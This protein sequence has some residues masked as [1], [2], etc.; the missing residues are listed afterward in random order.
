MESEYAIK[1]DKEMKQNIKEVVTIITP[2]INIVKTGRI[3][4]LLENFESVNRQSYPYIEHLVIDGASEDGT[5]EILEEY[6]KKGWIKYVSE[7]DQGS[8]DAMNK[9]VRIS[10][11]D[12][13]LILN[14]DDKFISDDAIKN[15]LKQ[16]I[17]NNADFC[18]SKARCVDFYGNETPLPNCYA[19]DIKKIFLEMTISH[20]TMLCKKSMFDYAL[21]SLDLEIGSDFDWTVRQCLHGAK[22][23]FLN[24]FTA[25]YHRAGISGRLKNFRAYVNE[26]IE[27][28]YEIFHNINPKVTRFDCKYMLHEQYIGDHI[29]EAIHKCNIEFEP[30]RGNLRFNLKDSDKL[31]ENL[32]ERNT[33]SNII[34]NLLREYFKVIVNGISLADILLSKGYHSCCIYGY[35]R[36]GQCVLEDLVINKFP[37][38]GVIDINY[39]SFISKD[40]LECQLLSLNDPIPQADVMIVTPIFYFDEIVSDLEYKVDYPI[41]PLDDFIQIEGTVAQF[42]HNK[43]RIV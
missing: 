5:K 32:W 10:K 18:Y 20:Q 40:A 1:G 38:L 37:V 8:Y 9:G 35:G 16:I 33:G 21:F 23:V 13:I 2:V 11:G 27:I 19:P 24:E 36:V 34:M 4:S 17:I 42:L 12:Y 30:Q 6:Q 15:S 43:G 39:E 25:Q 31:M 22:P 14:S 28:F 41:V 3:D 26:R 29:W 7:P